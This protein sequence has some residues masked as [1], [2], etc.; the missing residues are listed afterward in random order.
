MVNRIFAVRQDWPEALYFELLAVGRMVD[1]G[2]GQFDQLTQARSRHIADRNES[3]ISADRQDFVAIGFI[4]EDDLLDLTLQDD[5][6][7]RLGNWCLAG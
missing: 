4:F 5:L 3:F 7:A 2:P 1:P 6:R